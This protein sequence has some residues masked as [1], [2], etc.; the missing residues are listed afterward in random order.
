MRKH[1]TR[2]WFR[3]HPLVTSIG[4]ATILFL[5]GGCISEMD[6][7]TQTYPHSPNS[8]YSPPLMSV[9]EAKQAIR[10]VLETAPSDPMQNIE[11]RNDGFSF[12]QKG[13]IQRQL[14]GDPEPY[15]ATTSCKFSDLY[16]KNM[17]LTPDRWIVINKA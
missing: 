11:I 17:P 13:E 3:R 4:L 1:F 6:V 8:T 10:E 5:A 14:F 9:A 16:E 2:L 15:A 7:N 12:F